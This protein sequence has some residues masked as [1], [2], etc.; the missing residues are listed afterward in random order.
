MDK[1]NISEAIPDFLRLC[2]QLAQRIC[3]VAVSGQLVRVQGM[4]LEIEGL[5]LATGQAV[6][7]DCHSEQPMSAEVIAFNRDNLFAMALDETQTL[8]PRA[9]VREREHWPN[10]LKWDTTSPYTYGVQHRPYFPIG[11]ELLGRVL[12][13]LGQPIDQKGLLPFCHTAP[14]NQRI[15]NPLER[16]KICEPLDVGVRC[17]NGLLSMARGQRMGLFSTSGIGK[18]VLIGMMTKYTDADIIIVALVGERGREVKEFIED[19]LDDQSFRKTVVI[20]STAEESPLRRINAAIYATTLAEYFRDEGQHVLLIMD[21]LTRYI[22]AHREIALSVGEA[23][24]TRGY[25]ASVFS[26]IPPL[27]ERVGMGKMGTGSITGFYTVLVEGDDLQDPV[28]DAV[29]AVLDGHIV[30]SRLLADTGHYPAIDIESSVSRV[31]TLI[32]SHDE[33]QMVHQFKTLWSGYHRAQDM[34]TIG[35]YTKGTDQ[36]LDKAI[37]YYPK[38]CRYLRQGIQEHTT[39]AQAQQSLQTLFG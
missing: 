2:Q 24:A 27:L 20:A 29:R 26:K 37:E 3:P 35:A 16:R 7:I 34:I 25:P 33:L 15:I 17:I 19:I 8:Y 12:N 13:A 36:Q 9:R 23:P 32:K 11:R 10:V 1:K 39:Y 6:F 38:M 14:L 30:L 22:H 21:S 31:M 4:M 18:S 28:A 5:T